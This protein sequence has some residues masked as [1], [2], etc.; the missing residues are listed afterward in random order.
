MNVTINNSTR[1]YEYHSPSP[2][3]SYSSNNEP[4]RTHSPGSNASQ[5]DN[6][7]ETS[8]IVFAF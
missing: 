7:S 6:C 5:V 3:S 1:S 8:A 4:N 2:Q